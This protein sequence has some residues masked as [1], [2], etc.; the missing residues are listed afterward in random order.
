[1][2]ACVNGVH[3]VAAYGSV[4]AGTAVSSKAITMSAQIALSPAS[5]NVGDIINVI[6]SGFSSGEKVVISYGGISML[7]DVPVDSTGSFSGSFKAPGGKHG[8]IAV[9][10]SEADGI[11]ASSNFAMDIT[12]PPVPQAISP[13]D[14]STVGFFGGTRA[15]FHWAA[16]TDPSGVYD[17]LQIAGDASFKDIVVQQSGLA[18]SQYK[19]TK[20]EG[21]PHG[22]YYWRVRAVD[23]A[24]NTSDWA[25]PS[26][27]KSGF[28]STTIFIMILAVV[29]LGVLA[30]VLRRTAFSRPNIRHSLRDDHL[31]S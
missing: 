17:D 6:G 8:G 18:V 25:T 27:L 13:I 3:T 31:D 23:G 15:N 7:E 14:G 29:F 11:S 26:L 21:L 4:T 10:A 2:P 12:P 24:G 1:M 19:L 28:M 5:G 9:V 22:Q 20:A 16:V 30:A